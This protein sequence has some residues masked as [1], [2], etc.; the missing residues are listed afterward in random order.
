ME[1][2]RGEQVPS[3]RG[4]CDFS[5]TVAT[6][7]PGGML[8]GDASGREDTP[9]ALRGSLGLSLERLHQCVDRNGSGKDY[10][11]ESPQRGHRG[12]RW[13]QVVQKGTP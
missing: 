8:L 13:G 11:P 10:E 1:G 7:S 6:A 5:L 12:G 3:D 2:D 9:W 4:P